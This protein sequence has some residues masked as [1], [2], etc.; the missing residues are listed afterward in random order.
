MS[1][2][3]GAGGGTIPE[4]SDAALGS[5]TRSTDGTGT[6]GRT[7]SAETGMLA[8]PMV[9][10]SPPGDPLGGG[11][12][13]AVAASMGPYSWTSSISVPN[14]P[15][16]WTKATVVPRDPGRGAWSMTCPPWSL[17]DCS[18]SAQSATR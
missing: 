13:A 7:W 11:A 17:T 2:S 15:R 10:D 6:G 12:G 3:G 5:V 14:A 4:S 9:G 8:T 1:A 18:A 16:G